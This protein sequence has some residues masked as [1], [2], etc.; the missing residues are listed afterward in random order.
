VGYAIQ[1]M[2]PEE[3]RS[4]WELFDEMLAADEPAQEVGGA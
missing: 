3:A 4:T 2:S 1:K